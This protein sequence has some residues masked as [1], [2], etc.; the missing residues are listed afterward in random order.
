MAT[1]VNFADSSLE[2]GVPSTLRREAQQIDGLKG[3]MA[4]RRYQQGSVFLRGKD[5][6]KWVA[7]WR[8]DIV[9]P[10]GVVRR[11][12]HSTVLGTKSKDDLPTE[13]LAQ[14]RF[15]VILGRVNSP[16]YRPGRVSTVE[17]FSEWWKT[18]VLAQQKPSSIR[19]ANAHLRCHI[20]P[21]LGKLKL[22]DVTLEQQQVFVTH[23]SQLVSR[24]TVLNIMGTVSSLLNSARKQTY[25]TSAVKMEDLALPDEGVKEESRFF[26][27]EQVRQIL[28]LAAEPFRTMFCL[29]ATTGIRAGELLGLVVEDLDFERGLV[30]IR[31]SVIRGRVQSVKS[32]ASK[33]PLPMPAMLVTALQGHLKT[34]RKTPERW[35]FVNARGRAYSADK[36]VMQK[37]W[38]ILDALK[39]PRCGLHAFRHFHSTMLLELGAAPQVAQAQMRH[40]DPRI[41]LEV[42]SHVVGDSQRLAVEKVAEVL[43]PIGPKSDDHEEWIQ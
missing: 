40:S 29:A 32:K 38:P 33:K 16:E 42:Y 5:P 21:R 36:V 6:Q 8:E 27:A 37:L 4:R 34:W 1:A 15:D 17:E 20:V 10:D 39:I 9:G 28:N 31:R 35:L 12:R 18:N 14:R 11:V 30:N 43:A 13:K 25:F 19:A 2:G 7:R 3:N 22:D 24:K 41:T 26:T 23:L